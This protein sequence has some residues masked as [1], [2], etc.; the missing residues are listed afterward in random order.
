MHLGP[1]CRQ[2][3]AA[4]RTLNSSLNLKQDSWSHMWLTT[5]K[6]DNATKFIGNPSPVGVSHKPEQLVNPSHLRVIEFIEI[7]AW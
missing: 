7:P 4:R 5:K 3:A 6:S 1:T 2:T